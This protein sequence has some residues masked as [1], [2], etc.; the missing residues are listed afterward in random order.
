[1]EKPK[2]IEQSLKLSKSAI[3]HKADEIGKET[4]DRLK[5]FRRD[6]LSSVE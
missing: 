3:E 1:M 5:F 6:V 4:D 2:I